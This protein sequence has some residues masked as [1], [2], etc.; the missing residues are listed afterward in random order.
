MLLRQ[1]ISEKPF[2]T[3]AGTEFDIRN[4]PCF[5]ILRTNSF[6]TIFYG[7][8]FRHHD[9]NPSILKD[10]ELRSGIFYPDRSNFGI[11]PFKDDKSPAPVSKPVASG[12]APS[13]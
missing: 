1:I 6:L 9:A 7:Y 5:N 10:L 3:L 2:A 8:F 11:T 4:T 12:S 13:Q